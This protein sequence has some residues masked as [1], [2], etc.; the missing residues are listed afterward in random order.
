VM[1]CQEE[2][3]KKHTVLRKLV[4]FSLFSAQKDTI[5]KLAAS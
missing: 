5:V 1:K 3:N 4:C 2:N